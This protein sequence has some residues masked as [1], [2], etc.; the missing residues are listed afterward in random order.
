M[1]SALHTFT[2]IL[3]GIPWLK[4]TLS[5]LYISRYQ[6][7]VCIVTPVFI[8][9]IYTSFSLTLVPDS[10]RSSY[11]CQRINVTRKLYAEWNT[12]R[13]YL[14]SSLLIQHW[15]FILISLFPINVTDIGIHTSWGLTTEEGNCDMKQKKINRTGLNHV[16]AVFQ[17]MKNEKM[18]MNG[19]AQEK[20]QWKTRMIFKLGIWNKPEWWKEWALKE[21]KNKKNWSLN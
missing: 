5:T 11:F 16:A 12:L 8:G 14:I 21:G 18:K 4:S 20:K 3:Q 13:K 9:L 10:S 15:I 2:E 1:I 7:E 6:H 19:K 17:K